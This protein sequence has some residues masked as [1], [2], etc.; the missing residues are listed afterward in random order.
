[1]STIT[2]IFNYSAAASR[3][4]A[5]AKEIVI[6]PETARIIHAMLGFV[7]EAGEF[8]DPIKRLLF[9]GKP[10]DITNMREELGDFLWYWVLGVSACGGDPI[11]I[12]QKNIDKLRVR[13]P[14]K[15]TTESALV[16][17]FDAERAVLEGNCHAGH[18]GA[19]PQQG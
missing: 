8:A 9:Y 2:D 5:P 12:M 3:T 15:F 4:E 17:D 18:A 1:M 16:R 14:Q 6:D 7:T 13:F 11:D 19:Q 10:L